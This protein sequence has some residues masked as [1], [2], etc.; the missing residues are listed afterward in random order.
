MPGPIEQ[1][2]EELIVTL[3][4]TYNTQREETKQRKEM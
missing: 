2:L 3:K 1:K 4:Y